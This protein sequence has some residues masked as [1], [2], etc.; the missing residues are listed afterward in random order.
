MTTLSLLATYDELVRCTNVLING[1]C[2]E[3]F[4]QCALNQEAMRQK[5]SGTEQE[6]GRL[7]AALNKAQNE[8]AGLDKKLCHA[9]RKLEEENHKRRVAE[10]QR[11]VLERQVAMVRNLLLNDGGRN[12]ND[13][14]REKLQFLNNTTLNRQSNVQYQDINIDKLNTIAELDSTGSILSDLNCLSKS[15]NDIDASIMLQHHKKREWKEHRPSS[16][17]APKHRRSTLHKVA[18]LNSSDKI[19][20]TTT[21]VMPKDGAITASSTIEAIPGDENADPQAAP[22]SSRKRRKSSTEHSRSKLSHM[23]MNK[24]PVDTAPSAPKADIITSTSDSEDVYKPSPNIGGYT[25]HTKISRSHNFTAKTVIKP[26]LC[27]PC[28]KRIRF[29]KIV[30]KCRDCRATAHT[31][32]KDLVPLPCVPTGNTPTLRGIPGT[33]AD[34][35]PTIPPMVPSIVVHCIN[36]VELRGMNEQGLYRV[37]GA[38]VDTKSLKEKFLKGK[39]APNLSN[40]DIATICSTL[41]DFLR[42]LR[43]PL[44][45]VSLLGDFVRATTMTDKQDVDVAFYQAISELP[46]PNRDTL[47]FLILHLQ[48]VSSSPECKMPISN[49][50]KVFG[51]TLVGYSSQEPSLTMLSE[52]KQ[53][54][55]IVEGLLQLPSDYW[56]TYVNPASS[57]D[58]C[59]PKTGEL[60]HTPSTESLLKRS[61][62]RGFF[63]TPLTSSH[64]FARKNK[65][66]FATP[67]SRAGF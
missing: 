60:K 45:T 50:A 35:T 26:E 28:G 15:E 40:V 3:D 7:L 64:A 66:Y 6:C 53:Q 2:E 46:Q 10:E 49:L 61:I 52:T 44:I 8:I 36:E 65:K 1:S 25:L 14:T 38:A 41:K 42:S 59:T 56:A 37:N 43:E 63:N 21:V 24:V 30:Q 58:V 51:P 62:S 47:A 9:R 18:D 4:Q 67:P 29:G 12:L 48:R 33:I 23:D 17:Y 55:A 27:T 22:C 31:E 11:D 39:G 5:W 19:V 13:E 16:E 54:V 57:S 20:A 34:Y 32:C